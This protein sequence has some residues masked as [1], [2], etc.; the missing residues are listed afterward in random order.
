MTLQKPSWRE[1]T[2]STDARAI[3]AN[4]LAA[5]PGKSTS[6]ATPSPAASAR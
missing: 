1:L 2:A 4:G 6:S 5:K 3:Q